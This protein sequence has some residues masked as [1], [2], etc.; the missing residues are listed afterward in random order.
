MES[1]PLK[2]FC[3]GDVT[4]TKVVKPA[5]KDGVKTI[6]GLSGRDLILD[7][8]WNCPSGEYRIGIKRAYELFPT[9]LVSKLKKVSIYLTNKARV[10]SHASWHRF[11]AS[12]QDI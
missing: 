9:E 2:E 10:Y 1:Q 6:T 7:P 4:T 12:P 5:E 8:S 3:I 11:V